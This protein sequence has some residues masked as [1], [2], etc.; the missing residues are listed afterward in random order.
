MSSEAP[1][2]EDGDL[3]TALVALEPRLRRFAYGLTGS[4]EES[5]DLVQSAYER[6]LGRLEQWK[7]GSRLDSWMYR[8]VQTIWFNRLNSQAVRNRYLVQSDRADP[9]YRGDLQIESHITLER[10]REQLLRLPEEQRAVLLLV[11]VEGLSYKE[12]SAVLEVPIG[13]ITSRL[14]RAR[15]SLRDLIDGKDSEADAQNGVG[16]L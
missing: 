15:S 10:V 1:D 3:R 16:K 12:A 8:I 11:A 13:T 7:V 2:T 5:A 9:G 6:A 14:A 4:Q